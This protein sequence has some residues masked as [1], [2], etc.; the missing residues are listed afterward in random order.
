MICFFQCF[1]R[2]AIQKHR[3][4]KRLRE[5]RI[6]FDVAISSP[7]ETRI[8][9]KRWHQWSYETFKKTTCAILFPFMIENVLLADEKK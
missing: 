6:A 4:R 5:D 3:W 8:Q 2:G 7:R 9:G 1:F